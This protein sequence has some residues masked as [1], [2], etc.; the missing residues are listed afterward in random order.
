MTIT[1][2]EDLVF[3][4]HRNRMVGAVQSQH[5][6]PNGITISVVGGGQGLYGDGIEDFEVGAWQ[7]QGGDWIRLSEHDDVLG[8]RSKEQVTEIIQK[9]LAM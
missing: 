5:E 4:P 8:W 6:L 1:C 3:A 2:F 9:L 7:T